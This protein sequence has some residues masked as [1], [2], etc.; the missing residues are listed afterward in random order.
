MTA[1]YMCSTAWYT[2][3]VILSTAIHSLVIIMHRIY[4]VVWRLRN[5]LLTAEPM[6]ALRTGSDDEPTDCPRENP[7]R[8]YG[9]G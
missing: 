3:R 2:R 4:T 9:G 6:V 5:P 1:Q 7:E 8:A